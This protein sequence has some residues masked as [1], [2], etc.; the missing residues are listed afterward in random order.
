M[1]FNI[2]DTTPACYADAAPVKGEMGS[3]NKMEPVWTVDHSRF[4]DNMTVVAE[5]EGL[6][7]AEDWVLGAFVGDECRG[8]GRSVR[9][10][11]MF[12]GIAGKSGEKMNFR[13]HNTRTGEEYDVTESLSFQQKVGSLKAPLHLSSE[14]ATGIENVNVKENLNDK[15][16]YDLSGRRVVKPVKGIYI[17]G[18]RKVIF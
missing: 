5:I 13:L 4:A 12:I 2:Y 9:D 8:E 11:I 7:N 6:M 15:A 18:G 3:M 14:G 17:V 1:D 10:G 16:I